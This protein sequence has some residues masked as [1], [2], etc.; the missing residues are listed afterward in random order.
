MNKKA[1][2]VKQIIVAL[3]A[4]FLLVIVYLF[5]F[6]PGR[7]ILIDKV[8][9]IIP[10]F[11]T[12][13]PPS[14]EVQILGYNLDS[15]TLEFYDGLSWHKINDNKIK[16]GD[17]EINKAKAIEDF[18][19]KFYYKDNIRD[20]EK[21]DLDETTAQKLFEKESDLPELEILMVNIQT[22]KNKGDIFTIIQ[23]KNEPGFYGRLILSQTGVMTIE[24][25]N[26]ILTEDYKDS[27]EISRNSE[28]YT[29]ISPKL[30]TWADSITKT[31]IQIHFNT[32]SDFF[33]AQKI[34]PGLSVDLSK[35][36]TQC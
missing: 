29:L 9:T 25:N 32:G 10:G 13:K 8:K 36:S 33:C 2:A 17:K 35:P 34:G 11:N 21:F 3:I 6:G 23:S 26:A 30:K 20:T 18:T 31:P 16:L 14:P 22:I 12:T 27:E 28:T 1:L 5:L 4:V 24:R 7:E 15:E 19:T